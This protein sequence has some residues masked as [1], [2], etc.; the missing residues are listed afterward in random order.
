ML[1]NLLTWSLNQSAFTLVKFSTVGTPCFPC[2]SHSLRRRWW[3]RVTCVPC[4]YMW[5]PSTGGSTTLSAPTPS[6]TSSSARTNTTHSRRHS[7]TAASLT[8]YA[9]SSLFFLFCM[10]N[11]TYH[12][13]VQISN[14]EMMLGHSKYKLTNNNHKS[15]KKILGN[16]DHVHLRNLYDW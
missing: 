10:Q 8:Q 11:I 16:N 15:R 5:S 7:P 4:P 6:P 2:L 1:I 9:T 3:V 12:I 13:L 14:N